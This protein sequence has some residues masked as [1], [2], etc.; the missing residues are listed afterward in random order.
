MITIIG[1]GLAGCEAAWQCAQRGVPV[2]LIEMKPTRRSPAHHE[3]NF[4]ELV[5]SNSFRGD[6]LENAP[7]LLKEELRRC[8]SL[9]MTI[10]ERCRVPAGGALAVDRAVFSSYITDEIKNHPLINVITR[11]ATEIPSHGEVVIATGPLTD[12]LFAEDIARLLGNR[13][14]LY[15]YDA[16]APLVAADSIDPE[17]SFKAARYGRGGADYINCPMNKEEFTLFHQAL[18]AAREAPVHGFEDKKVFEGCMPVEVMARRGADTLRFGCM[19][20]VGLRDER[21]GKGSWAILQLR[22]DNSAGLVYNMVGFQ[23][24]L[25]FSEQKRVFSM[26]PALRNAEFLRYGVM[27]RNSYIQSPGLLNEWFALKQNNRI[28]FAGQI[29]GVEGYIESCASGLVCG[30]HAARRFLGQEPISW[31]KE[32]AIGAL[33]GYI[34]GPGGHRFEPMNINFGLLP[35]L[36][37]PPG[38]KQEKNRKISERALAAIDRLS[39]D[40]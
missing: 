20:P 11:E 26:I 33:C 23:T 36:D 30:I 4:G 32:T 12:G 1:A 28:M 29:T 19:R 18:S 37:N 34:S 14:F 35:A 7:G 10:A 13:D 8:K 21:T 24:H 25:L 15:F 27:H 38:D 17:H 16:S 9:V 39:I 2:N 6:R 3:D 40:D 22:R 5:C 31:P